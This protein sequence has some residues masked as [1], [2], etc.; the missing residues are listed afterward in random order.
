MEGITS[1]AVAGD[2]TVADH[3]RFHLARDGVLEQNL[4]HATAV[5][6]SVE[7]EGAGPTSG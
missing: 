6:D 4:H 3:G 2:S 5:A 7:I 1:T